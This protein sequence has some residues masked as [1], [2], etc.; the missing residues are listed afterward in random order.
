[1]K[2]N[3]LKTS[4]QWCSLVPA[5]YQL[6]IMDPDGWD[7]QNWHYSYFEELISFDEFMMRVCNS[8]ISFRGTPNFFE[9]T[10]NDLNNE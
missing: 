6:S 3:T 8:T 9:I 4:Q 1:M 2:E 7:R 5:K 10:I